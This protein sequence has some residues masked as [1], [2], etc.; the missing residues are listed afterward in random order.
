MANLRLGVLV[1]GGGTNLQAIIDAIERG[2]VPAE[3]AVVISNVPTA[4]ALQRA[5][6]HGTPA[7]VVNHHDFMDRAAFEQALIAQLDSRQVELVCLAGFMRVLSPVFVRRFP[8]RIMN[9]HP[10]LLPAFKGLWGHHVHEAVIAARAR[11][12]G[13][14]V[15]FVT[16]D[17]DGGPIVL[18]RTVPV[19]E[20]DDAATLAARVLVE[21]HKAYPEAIRRFAAGERMTAD[22][23]AGAKT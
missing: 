1:S 13:C 3:I 11:V 21:E 18:Q 19:L 2:E 17:V 23:E 14:T 10:A 12:S 8:G 5:A 9:I 4:P 22:G 6:R 16:E 15:H 7:V 20:T